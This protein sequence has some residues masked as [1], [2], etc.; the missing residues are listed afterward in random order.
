MYFHLL[1]IAIISIA[2]VV[3]QQ[4]NPVELIPVD[5]GV[6]DRGSLSDSLRSMPIDPRQN[7]SFEKLY[8]VVGSEEVYVRQSGGLR[9]VF[10]YPVYI[11]TETGAIPI[12]PA[13]TV[14]CIGEVTQ[15]VLRQLGVLVTPDIQL[16]KAQPTS[17]A[18]LY[19]PRR[20]T[21][22]RAPRNTIQFLD[23]ESYRRQ[24]LAMFVLD[25]LLD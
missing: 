2:A 19:E 13:G 7:Q 1:S 10:K 24:R 25:V 22:S 20:T 14:Y 9:A 4:D 8:K 21:A 3:L 5:G 23:D 15:D 18:G 17:A 6:A 12:V 11:D 16:L